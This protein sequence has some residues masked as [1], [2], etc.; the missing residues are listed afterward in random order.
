V[1]WGADVEHHNDDDDDDDDNDDSDE[2]AEASDGQSTCYR[3]K[4][5]GERHMLWLTMKTVLL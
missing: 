5:R 4:M 1:Y 3:V 2:T